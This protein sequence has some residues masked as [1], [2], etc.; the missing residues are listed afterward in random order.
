M[1]PTPEHRHVDH[2]VLPLLPRVFIIKLPENDNEIVGQ[3][4]FLEDENKKAVAWH[5]FIKPKYRR[6]KFGTHLLQCAQK[7]YNEIV[8][9]WE[10][11]AGHDLALKC[12]FRSRKADKVDGFRLVW[13]KV[14]IKCKEATDLIGGQRAGDN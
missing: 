11:D 13:K 6:Q 8:S 14:E 2:A 10:S 3:A 5:L 7:Y 9:D 4:L 12:G 1:A